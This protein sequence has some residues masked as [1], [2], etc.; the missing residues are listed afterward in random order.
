[1]TEWLSGL[2]DGAEVGL[3]FLFLTHFPAGA[4]RGSVMH[5]QKK[6]LRG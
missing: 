4:S 2:I 5:A 1:M 6:S 3:L